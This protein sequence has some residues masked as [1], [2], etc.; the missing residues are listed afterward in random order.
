[1]NIIWKGSPNKDSN[2]LPVTKIIIHWFGDNLTTHTGIGAVDNQFQKPNGTSAH[3]AVENT[4][5][6]QYVEEE[7][8]AYHAGNYPVNQE[9]I[10]IEH[11][12]GPNRAPSEDTYETSGKLIH[13]ISKRYNIPLDREHILGHKEVKATA[14]PG[15]LDIDRLIQIAKD[16]DGGCEEYK[17]KAEYWVDALE[18]VGLGETSKWSTFRKRVEELQA[19][20]D[21]AK[22]WSD[23][24]K[25]YSLPEDSKWSVYKET[26]N[27][28][29]KQ[30]ELAVELS[31]SF[32]GKYND[33]SE[34]HRIDSEALRVL[35]EET[36]PRMGRDLTTVTTRLMETSMTIERLLAQKYTTREAFGFLIRSLKGV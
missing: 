27:N 4:T 32:E 19:F 2:R 36:I 24:L 11:S 6:H 16:Q 3:Y 21:K 14:C 5:I 34:A 17:E 8:V 22:Y 25:L 15:T 13:E 20:K 1:M 12:A 9:S 7:N 26:V 28:K 10:G 23:A 35:N 33:A 30:Y 31:N 18:L 29:Q